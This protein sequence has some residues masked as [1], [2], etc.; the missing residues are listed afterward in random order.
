MID[1][2]DCGATGGRRLAGETEVL[3]KTC[4]SA[5]LSILYVYFF[6]KINLGILFMK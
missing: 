2:G 3:E 6:F 4:P 5:A 1:D